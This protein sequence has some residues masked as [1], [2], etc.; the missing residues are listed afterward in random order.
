MRF[1]VTFGETKNDVTSNFY[2]LHVVGVLVS[3]GMSYSWNVLLFCNLGSFI[4]GLLL[5]TPIN[6]SERNLFS[7]R[8]RFF[9]NFVNYFML[10]ACGGMKK[11]GR[12]FGQKK[13][14]LLAIGFTHARRPFTVI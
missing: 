6:G 1:F 7:L 14:I 12:K 9:V 11:R 5:L 3:L 10:R 4:E 13:N 2:Y 8:V